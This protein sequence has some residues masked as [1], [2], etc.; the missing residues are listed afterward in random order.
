[1]DLITIGII[2]LVTLAVLLILGVHIGV[3]LG[4]VGIAGM[5]SI[6]GFE[7]SVKSAADTIYHKL[8]SF[9]LITIPLFILMGYLA[10]SGGISSAVF[11]ALNRWVGRIKGGIGI[12]T[13]A[14]C[15][16]FGAVTGSSLVTSSVFASIC[17]P[18][19]RKYGYDKKLPDYH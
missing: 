19:M 15:T 14:S 5:V 3:A 11:E 16:A 10:S 12:A 8:A 13:V 4:L 9:D 1:M 2:G 7:A 18:E 17:A 6:V